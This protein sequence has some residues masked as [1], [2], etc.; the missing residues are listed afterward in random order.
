MIEVSYGTCKN[1]FACCSPEVVL[2]KKTENIQFIQTRLQFGSIISVCVKWFLNTHHEND[3][4]HIVQLFLT[5]VHCCA[6]TQVQL[7]QQVPE[8]D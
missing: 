4:V 6:S 7:G 3:Y 2:N 8:C 5:S 1:M